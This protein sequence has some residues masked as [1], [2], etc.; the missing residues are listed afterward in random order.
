MEDALEKL[1]ACLDAAAETLIPA[2][3][4]P[5]KQKQMAKQCAPCSFSL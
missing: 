3:I 1:Q 5:E 2:E 4:N